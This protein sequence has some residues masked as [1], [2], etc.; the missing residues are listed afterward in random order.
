MHGEETAVSWD[1][2]DKDG[3][4]GVGDAIFANEVPCYFIENGGPVQ[5]MLV[6]FVDCGVRG[7]GNG[8][9]GHTR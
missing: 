8:K 9:V 3:V 6:S 2:V 1:A 5:G 7:N 4:L